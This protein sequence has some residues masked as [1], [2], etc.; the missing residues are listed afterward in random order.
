[1]SELVQPMVCAVCG[2]VLDQ[3]QGQWIHAR[4]TVGKS[5]HVAVP[6]QYGAVPLVTRCDF[7]YA[8]VDLDKRWTLPVHDFV[9]PMINTGSSGNWAACESCA[10]L[11]GKGDWDAVIIRHLESPETSTPNDPIYHKF[12]GDLYRMVRENAF[13]SIRPW[14]A[15]DE[16]TTHHE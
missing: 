5:D 10:D 12:L 11:I 16:V 2:Q 14:R 6:V 13:G 9:M 3:W 8:V 15:G 1:M 4:E 7:C